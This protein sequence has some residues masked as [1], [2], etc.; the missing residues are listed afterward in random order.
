MIGDPDPYTAA[1]NALQFFHVYEIV[2]STLPDRALGL[3]ARRT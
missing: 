3:D 2:I 1:M